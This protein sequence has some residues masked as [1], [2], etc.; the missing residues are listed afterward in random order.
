ML[1]GKNRRTAFVLKDYSLLALLA[2]LICNA[3]GG[4]AGRLAR[5]LA[6]AA[7]A[8]FERVLEVA[9]TQS[10]DPFHGKSSFKE[11]AL[12]HRVFSM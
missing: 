12:T 6:L 4:L 5:G 1:S 8:G 3:A 10:F 9:G 2:L 7:A 11:T